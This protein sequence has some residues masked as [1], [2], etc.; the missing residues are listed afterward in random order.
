VQSSASVEASIARYGGEQRAG[1][2]VASTGA[3][4]SAAPLLL[5]AEEEKQVEQSAQDGA[6]PFLRLNQQARAEGFW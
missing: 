4:S 6:F 5:I 2:S 1:A 3:P